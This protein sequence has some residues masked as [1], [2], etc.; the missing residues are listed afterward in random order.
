M[1]APQTS[2]ESGASSDKTLL[3]QVARRPAPRL[4]PHAR[5]VLREHTNAVQARAYDLRRRLLAAL[6]TIEAIADQAIRDAWDGRYTET[7]E[8]ALE[9]V[10]DLARATGRR[11]SFRLR[12]A[13]SVDARRQL[14]L[15]GFGGRCL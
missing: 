3:C 6:E 2:A 8:R 4:T 1:N 11:L 13:A 5:A 7:E 14:P 12:R 15:P 10:L 9:R